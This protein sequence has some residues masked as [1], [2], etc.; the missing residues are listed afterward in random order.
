MRHGKQAARESGMMPISEIMAEA[1][2]NNHIES[3][4]RRE[5]SIE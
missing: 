1:A 5:A 3:A 2:E 4:Y